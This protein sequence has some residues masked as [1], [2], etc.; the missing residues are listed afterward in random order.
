MQYF[1]LIFIYL[2]CTNTTIAQCNTTIASFPY[3]ENFEAGQG[4]FTTGGNNNDWA[5]GT[6]SKNIITNAASGTKCWIT[7]GLTG[8][9]Y[10]NAANAWLQSPCFNFSSLVNPQISFSVFWETERRFDGASFQFSTDGGSIWQTLGTINSNSNCLGSN[11]FN[12]SPITSLGIAGF[13]GT[14]LPTVGNCEGTGGSDG[15]VTAKHALTGLAGQ[16]TVIFRFIFGAGTACNSYN[17]FAVDDIVIADAAPNSANF[18]FT[19]SSN[20]TVAFTNTSSVCATG[21]SW[22]FGDNSSPSN[23]SSAEN[24]T[25][26]FTTPG[27]Y[28]VLLTVTFQ[29]GLVATSNKTV[30]VLN[31]SITIVQPIQ[32]FGNGNGQL[33]ANVF[34]GNGLYNYVWSTTPTQ[35]TSTAANLITGNYTVSVSSPNACTINASFVLTQPNQLIGSLSSA[36]ELCTQKNG[37]VSALITGGVL[38]YTYSWNNGSFNS[39]INNLSAGNYT[40]NIRDARNCALTLFTNIKDSINQLTLNFGNDTSFCPGNEMVLNAGNYNSYLWQ[41]FSNTAIF[42][43]KKS[44]IYFVKVTDADGCSISD[45]I[46]VNV[47]CSD[48][49]FP[50]AFSPNKDASNLNETFGP[51]GN[52]QALT[53][54]NMQVYGRWGQLIF[55]TSNPFNKWN[56]KQNNID[57][58]LG[59]YVWKANY[60][61]NN[62]PQQFKNGTVMIIR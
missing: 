42:T 18:L 47:D 39:T 3:F 12:F 58:E 15:W 23:T 19:C 48:I 28:Q 36:N 33:M 26:I 17:G 8:N 6:P 29:N 43:V 54:F 46:K 2:L 32:C 21:F 25:H 56:G 41:D 13:S 55:S 22:N 34:G 45:T 49:Y 44:G 27:I 62:K 9:N 24:P 20:N 50:S 31:V 16:T 53:N 59:I 51:I 57:M 40:I 60:S 37:A 11:W 5:Y 7:G 10:S 52:L 14:S 30:T 35:T 61:I 4:N 38:P 1:C